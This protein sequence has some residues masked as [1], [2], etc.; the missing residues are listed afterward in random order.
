MKYTDILETREDGVITLSAIINDNTERE[1][2]FQSPF[3]DD[4]VRFNKENCITYLIGNGK[5]YQFSPDVY[6]YL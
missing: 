3:E 1:I 4:L 2:I 6:K 5:Y